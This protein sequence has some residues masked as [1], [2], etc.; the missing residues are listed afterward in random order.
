M[1]SRRT[2]IA[3]SFAAAAAGIPVLAQDNPITEALVLRDPA[4]P[5]AGN[6]K[7]DITIVEYSDYQCPYCRK[8]HPVLQKVVKEDGNVRVVFKIWPIFGAASVYALQ[9]VL[10]TRPQNK[11]N[12]AH[13]ALMLSGVRLTDSATDSVLAGI[14]VNVEA[15]K[16]TLRKDIQEIGSVL[17]RNHMQAEALGFQGTPS[18]IIG[19]FRVPGALTEEV[20]KQ[21]I[22][23][24]RKALK[25]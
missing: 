10:A 7:G 6:P 22:A 11:Y 18:F 15:A 8:V 25:G 24:A 16:A 5:A 2:L 17:K 1:I 3:G 13:S 19:K 21:A 20:F 4:I 14:G 12:E 9:M 23:D